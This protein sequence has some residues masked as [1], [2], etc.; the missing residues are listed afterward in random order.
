MIFRNSR[1]R[2][3]PHVDNLTTENFKINRVTEFKYLGICLDEELRFDTHANKMISK[4]TLRIHYILRLKRQI[5]PKKFPLIFNAVVMSCVEYDIQIWA[6]A[7]GT[8]I[9]RVQKVVANSLKS[10]VSPRN[11]TPNTL[12]EMFNLLRLDEYANYYLS[13]FAKSFTNESN[14]KIPKLLQNFVTI[15]ESVHETRSSFAFVIPPHKTVL[16]EKSVKYR[17]IKFWNNLPNE[18]KN[19]D[20]FD[21]FK[22]FL[23][24][25][26]LK[27]KQMD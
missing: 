5:P 27:N 3:I 23:N 26:I 22:F 10:W 21:Y 15:H 14:V 24:S 8:S 25:Y 16:Y 18:I 9:A 11:C 6:G 13:L 7:T 1:T 20:H 19:T 2:K 17:L 12:Y 4:I